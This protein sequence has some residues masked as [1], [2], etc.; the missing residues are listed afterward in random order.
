MLFI[1]QE[2]KLKAQKGDFTGIKSHRELE[3]ELELDS[4]PDLLCH[5][6]PSHSLF[7]LCL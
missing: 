6:P 5:P 1:S 4:F 7:S 2:K 3:A